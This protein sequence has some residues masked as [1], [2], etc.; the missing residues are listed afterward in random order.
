MSKSTKE[1]LPTGALLFDSAAYDLGC[2]LQTHY[3]PD[4]PALSALNHGM[5]LIETINFR[6]G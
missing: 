3:N 4:S 5:D 6:C 1:P 2:G